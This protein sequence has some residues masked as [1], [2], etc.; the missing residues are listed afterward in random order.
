MYSGTN[1][2]PQPGSWALALLPY[3]EKRDV[4]DIWSNGE[5]GATLP[6]YPTPGLTAA[7][8]QPA[9]ARPATATQAW[10]DFDA[11]KY[12][13][14]FVCPSDSPETRNPGDTWCSY[15]VNRGAN[16]TATRNLP[17]PPNQTGGNT[18]VPVDSPMYG[19]CMDQF[20]QSQYAGGA[21]V[22]QNRQPVRVGMDYITNHD[23]S[24]TTLLMAES[25][26][27]PRTMFGT[28]QLASPPTSGA[29]LRLLEYSD[30]TGATYPLYYRPTSL[31]TSGALYDGTVLVAPTGRPYTTTDIA[32]LA[33]GV[34]TINKS[35][36][37]PPFALTSTNLYFP[38]E[39][40]LGFEWGNLASSSRISER[41][42][43][44][45]SGGI[46]V[47]FCDGHQQFISESMD[48]EV[49][50]H[51]MTPWSAGAYRTYPNVNCPG[52]SGVLD[53]AS[54]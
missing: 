43:S 9:G 2:I 36:S 50:R 40:D 5:P 11:Y 48:I 12:I 21:P 45:H 30:N 44:R 20:V 32:T 27:T 22:M 16:G 10:V 3:L 25:L 38:C 4:Y 29:Y 52:P 18:G 7:P 51:L 28:G 14:V 35:T 54:Y 39:L 6:I 37:A 47:S 31:W 41:I 17:T 46:V 33:A 42:L 1:A 23:G 13:P 53:D 15:V 8:M 34:L 49:F 24:A 19:V 26:L